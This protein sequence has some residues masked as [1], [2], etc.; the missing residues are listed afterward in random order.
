MI[1]LDE[2]SRNVTIYP[3]CGKIIGLYEDEDEEGERD[4]DTNEDE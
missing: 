4:D 1:R 3:I 2:V